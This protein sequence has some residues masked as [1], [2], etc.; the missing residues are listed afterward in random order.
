WP[1][2]KTGQRIR[3]L[4]QGAGFV[5]RTGCGLL[6]RTWAGQFPAKDFVPLRKTAGRRLGS[7]GGWRERSI[8]ET[9]LISR[10]GIG[11]SETTPAPGEP[12]GA[13]RESVT[14]RLWTALA[15]R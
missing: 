10:A 5:V 7:C 9:C 11:G 13:L 3:L 12:S 6:R 15:T 4:R 2:R 14:S 1:S 8:G